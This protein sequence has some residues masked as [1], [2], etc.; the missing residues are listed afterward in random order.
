MLPVPGSLI[1]LTPPAVWL[2]GPTVVTANAALLFQSAWL[3]TCAPLRAY[4]VTG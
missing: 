1:A 3:A 4:T 2:G